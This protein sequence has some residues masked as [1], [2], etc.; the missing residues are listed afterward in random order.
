MTNKT[1]GIR[2]IFFGTSEFAVP[3]L[4]KLIDEKYNITAVVTQPDKPV[5]RK[6]ILTP[7]PVKILAEEYG[8]DVIQPE[9]LSQLP[10]IQS[11]NLKSK[12]KNLKLIVSASYGQII[13][14]HILDIPKYGALNVHPSL[15][16]K[17]RGPSPIQY[18]ILNGDKETGVTIML[19]D[20]K[21]D[22]G[23]I[24]TQEK[25]SVYCREDDIQECR[26]HRMRYIDLHDKLSQIGAELLI[27]TIPKWLAKEIQPVPQDDAN[28]TYTKII[29][30][31]DGKIDWTKS[32]EEIERQIRAFFPRPGC[33][34]ILNI[35]G[36][37][38][39]VKI[40][41]GDIPECRLH[42]M[43]REGDIPKCRLPKCRL[44]KCRLQEHRLQA[45]A[46]QIIKTANK[47]MAII[48]GSG[49]L[50]IL[51][52]QMEGKKIM[53]GEEFLNGYSAAIAF[54]NDAQ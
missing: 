17:Y 22:H 6:Q 11:R 30:K 54:Q 33:W 47:K 2:I 53:S 8:I 40:L 15:L 35:D 28:A 19:M 46:N 26:L 1:Q 39:R 18:T 10:G 3:I 41:E 21:M 20:E 42:R 9:N 14:K 4:Q 38:K 50:E 52:L 29:T 48:C 32:A 7:S 34:T 5:G 45:R 13:P 24:L 44:P 23:P 37:E 51:K 12:I 36:K 31:E 43:S 27:E 25:M 16:P 49:I